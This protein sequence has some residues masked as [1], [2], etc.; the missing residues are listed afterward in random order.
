MLTRLCCFVKVFV[1]VVTFVF[2]LDGEDT[3][4]VP[5]NVA[6]AA[7]L[8]NLIAPPLLKPVPLSVIV[9]GILNAV[10]PLISSAAPLALMVVPE[11]PDAPNAVL[12][13]ICITPA[14]ILVV[15]R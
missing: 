14:V 1:P 4:I 9:S 7:P 11:D 5:V 12:F 8:T 10:D 13:C 6:A 2:I 15:P 3:V